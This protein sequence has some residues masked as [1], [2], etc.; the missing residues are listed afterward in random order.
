[1]MPPECIICHKKV[2]PFSKKEGL[3]HFAKRESDLQWDKEMEVSGNTGH[4]PYAAWFC[5][6]HYKKALFVRNEF[7]DCAINKIGK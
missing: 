2:E 4:P 7:I 1:M 6:K 3:I 5:K